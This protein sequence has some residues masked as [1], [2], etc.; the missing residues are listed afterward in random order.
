MLSSV[1]ESFVIT[2][3]TLVLYLQSAKQV[4]VVYWHCNLVHYGYGVYPTMRGDKSCCLWNEFFLWCVQTGKLRPIVDG[5]TEREEEQMKNMLRR[6]NTLAKVQRW[7]QS[8]RQFL[9]KSGHLHMWTRAW[10]VAA[11]ILAVVVEE[12]SCPK[13]TFCSCCL[14]IDSDVIRVVL[15]CSCWFPH[16]MPLE[17][18]VRVIQVFL[19]YLCTEEPFL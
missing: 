9:C 12:F 17:F 2:V 19:S 16:E 6:V 11:S 3:C 13:L 18:W 14:Y 1:S 5:L 4:S 7:V 15:L 8:P 10:K